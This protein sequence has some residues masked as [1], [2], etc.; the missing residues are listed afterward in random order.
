MRDVVAARRDE[1]ITA[2]DATVRHRSK[3]AAAVHPTAGDHPTRRTAARHRAIRARTARAIG[4][5]PEKRDG[6][7][8]SGL[9][10]AVPG[11]SGSR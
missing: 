4:R 7:G 9:L 5:G 3:V 10:I 11:G 6:R 1:G 2:L 8:Q